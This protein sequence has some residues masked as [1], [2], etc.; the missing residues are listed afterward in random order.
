MMVV[1][2]MMMVMVIAFNQVS[3]VGPS[4]R[5]PNWR[6]TVHRGVARGSIVHW[7]VHWAHSLLLI[8]GIRVCVW[9]MRM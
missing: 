3:K 5:L 2:M 8:D 1:V 4:Y 9:L 6:P 7:M